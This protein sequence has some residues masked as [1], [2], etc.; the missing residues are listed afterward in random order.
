[1]NKIIAFIVLVL[2]LLLTTSARATPT[3]TVTA[4]ATVTITPGGKATSTPT[5]TPTPLT[6]KELDYW[7][8]KIN[9]VKKLQEVKGLN[10]VATKGAIT[11]KAVYDY[12]KTA[13]TAEIKAA[14]TAVSKITPTF[15]PS[16]TIIG[17][18]VIKK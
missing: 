8:A 16:K 18:E 10:P 7:K 11:D 9:P 15:T 6:R 12:I 1:M 4:T 3:P 2:L 13:P 14:K 17:T 5:L